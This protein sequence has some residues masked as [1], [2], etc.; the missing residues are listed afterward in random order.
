MSE[1]NLLT[2]G[3][4]AQRS[5]L[6]RVAYRI[7]GSLNDADDAVQEAW[8]RLQRTAPGEV[9]NVAGWLT[10]VIARI[11]LDMLRAR[12]VRKED[13]LPPDAAET[14]TYLE[15]PAADAEL[16]DSMGVALLVVLDSLA[17]AER[18][19]FVLHDVFGMKFEEIAPIVN[20]TPAAARQLASRGRRRVQGSP[21]PDPD[22]SRQREIVSA[23]L[24][25]SREGNF[26]ALL[27]VLD[28]DVVLRADP[29]AV[30]AARAAKGAPALAREI[31]GADAVAKTFEGRA[32]AAQLALVEGA[33][34]LVF[35]PGGTPRAVFEFVVVSG[36]IVEITLTADPESLGKLQVSKLA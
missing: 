14:F 3:F 27:A 13:P 7:L 29:A 19:A 35:A 5:H 33:I 22:E 10:T 21:A 8:L 2:T 30:Q 16:A 28:P 15:E 26:A 11:C 1:E 20:R 6:R 32:Q 23:F 4:E 17:P 25:A 24:S 9:D 31:R 34:G 36:R 18:V 12:K